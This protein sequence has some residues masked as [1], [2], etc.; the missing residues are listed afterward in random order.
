MRESV[1]DLDGAFFAWEE[2]EAAVG[3]V[4]REDRVAGF[5]AEHRAKADGNGFARVRYLQ[6]SAAV[7]SGF[8]LNNHAVIT[9][10]G[11]AFHVVIT[12]EQ[13]TAGVE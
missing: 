10:L 11:T 1:A 9:V 2:V 7:P 13:A 3:V 8:L 5:V 4:G 12:R 6:H